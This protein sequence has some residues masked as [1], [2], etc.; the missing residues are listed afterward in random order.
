[1]IQIVNLLIGNAHKS[2]T[3]DKVILKY[4]LTYQGLLGM[5]PFSNLVP[6]Y[7]FYISTC[8]CLNIMLTYNGYEN[9]TNKTKIISRYSSFWQS[10]KALDCINEVNFLSDYI[11]MK[12]HLLTH[13]LYDIY[14]AWC[15]TLPHPHHL[16]LTYMYNEVICFLMLSNMW[17]TCST[18]FFHYYSYMAWYSTFPHHFHLTVSMNLYVSDRCSVKRFVSLLVSI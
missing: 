10:N 16:S 15:P 9:Q 2:V 17:P 6:G 3:T 12:H 1:M 5:Y 4:N 11:A 18:S 7:N 8:N 14:I 13:F